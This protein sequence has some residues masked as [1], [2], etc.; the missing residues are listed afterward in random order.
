[1]QVPKVDSTGL[2]KLIESFY[3]D[4]KLKRGARGY[5]GKAV[6]RNDRNPSLSIFKG[7]SGIGI[8]KDHSTGEH[9]DAVAFL[10]KVVG[11]SFK[12]AVETIG[13]KMPEIKQ[14]PRRFV[15][16]QVEEQPVSQARIDSLAELIKTRRLAKPNKELRRRGF[17]GDDMALIEFA[18][19]DNGNLIIPLRRP[20]GSLVN[21]KVR[22]AKELNGQR[23][24]YAIAG[25]GS[26]PLLL[27]DF[28]HCTAVFVIEGELNAAI[29]YA[30]MI[31]H[32]AMIAA[33]GLPGAS[34][35]IPDDVMKLLSG[36]TVYIWADS[37]QAGHKLRL[38]L[39]DDIGAATGLKPIGL[40]EDKYHRDLCEIAGESGREKLYEFLVSRANGG[41]KYSRIHK[42]QVVALATGA[43]HSHRQAAE[44][45]AS[46]RKLNIMS[47][48]PAIGK[49]IERM[50]HVPANVL[51]MA[52]KYGLGDIIGRL[53]DNGGAKPVSHVLRHVDEHA[54]E[55][56]K[57][58][59]IV[60]TEK[61]LNNKGERLILVDDWAYRLSRWY[62]KNVV[63]VVGPAME[64]LRQAFQKERE[65]FI[66]MLQALMPW[67]LERLYPHRR[68]SMLAT[69]A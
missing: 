19:D 20:D 39:Q 8:W 69:A 30:T 17:V 31:E 61:G 55:L 64:R 26:Y 66:S 4:A 14:A 54:V 56:A 12:E 9:G 67:H 7:K 11:M 3:P 18:E 46:R 21:A 23:Y 59:G 28:N 42:A 51:V 25:A 41:P 50:D 38:R 37:D 68:S 43:A 34:S 2:A 33:I 35:S 49:W 13:G 57:E 47:A 65:I 22:L 29:A 32:G 24:R 62:Y 16:P 58:I 5:Y 52:F 1:M 6:W 15:V 27:G 63:Q 45:S 44:L 53:I 10:C 48:A 36:K 60:R 40:P